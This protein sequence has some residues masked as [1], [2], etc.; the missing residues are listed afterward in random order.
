MFTWR[1]PEWGQR[2]ERAARVLRTGG[3]LLA[4]AALVVAT[5]ILVTFVTVETSQA[6]S[7]KNDP[8]PLA[9]QSAT[10]VVAKQLSA[11]PWGIQFAIQSTDCCVNCSDHC[12][13]SAGLVAADRPVAQTHALQGNISSPQMPLSSIVS[14][15]Q[16]R[17][18]RITL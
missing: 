10:Q 1:T 8:A 11:E 4:R 9:T 2:R 14:D 15:A 13:S 7:R 17:P 12:H 16:F 6:C 3:N 5:L 18:P